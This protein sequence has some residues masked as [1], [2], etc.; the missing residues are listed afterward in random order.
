MLI[1]DHMFINFGSV[2]HATCL[3]GTIWLLGTPEY[4]EDSVMQYK[5]A[6]IP[7]AISGLHTTS[8]TFQMSHFM[9]SYLKEHQNYQKSK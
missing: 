2:V 9:I 3:L 6:A 8:K 1:R 7:M 4:F 5:S